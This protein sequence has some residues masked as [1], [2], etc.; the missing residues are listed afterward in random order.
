MKNMAGL[1]IYKGNESCHIGKLFANI[2][3][4]IANLNYY[5]IS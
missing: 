1:F 5:H 3:K 2:L 4:T